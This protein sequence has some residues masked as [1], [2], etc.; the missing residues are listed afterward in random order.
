MYKDEQQTAR[1]DR[2][3][4]NSTDVVVVGAGPS[5]SAAAITC[6]QHG[7]RVVMV[8]CARFP[9]NRPGETLHPGVE[10]IVTALG[11]ELDSCLRHEGHWVQ[12]AGKVSFQR[13]GSTDGVAWKGFHVPRADFDLQLLER[14]RNLGVKVCQPTNAREPWAVGGRVAGLVVSDGTRIASRMLVDAAGNRHWLARKMGL[15][16]ECASRPLIAAYGYSVGKLDD[17][18]P[19]LEED[20]D[21]WTWTS[22]VKPGVFQWTRL[23]FDGTMP[24]HNWTPNRFRQ[25]VPKGHRRGENVAWRHVHA[26]AGPGYFIVGDAASVADPSASHGVMKA[27]MSGMMAGHL[28]AR[29]LVSG[30]AEKETAIHYNHWQR[31]WFMHDLAMSRGLYSHLPHW[32]DPF[33]RHPSRLRS[34]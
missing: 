22:Q 32:R 17:E 34:N 13:Y 10:P 21:G 15:H 1:T 23:G 2:A 7:L 29:N 12:W 25:L 27:M 20:A 31:Q 14:A 9:R 28:I 5:G 11:I 4:V 19:M 8:E 6:A 24:P 16:K 33:R 26:S 30:I 18:S 3:Q